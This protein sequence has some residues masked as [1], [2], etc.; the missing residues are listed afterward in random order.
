ME[1][2]RRRGSMEETWRHGGDVETWR[3]RGDVDRQ[4]SCLALSS[5]IAVPRLLLLFRV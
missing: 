3:R 4:P 5:L 1:A 2:W